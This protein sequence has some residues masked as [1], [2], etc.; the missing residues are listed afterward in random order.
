MNTL[1]R[2]RLASLAVAPAV[3]ALAACAQS[4]ST[5]ASNGGASGPAG[6]VRGKLTWLVRGNQNENDWQQNVALP[7][8]KELHPQVEI[9]LVVASPDVACDEKV[10]SLHAGGTPPDVHNGIVGTFIQLYAQDKLLELTPLVARD[11]VDLKP[12]GGSERDADMCRGGKQWALPILS[13]LTIITY[14]NITLFEQAGVALPPTSWEDKTWTWDRLIEAGRK[15]T[16]RWGEQDAVYG[17]LPDA[18]G[19]NFMHAMPYTWGADPWPK[20]FYAQGIAQQ[21]NWTAGPVVEATQAYQDLALKHRIAPRQG[22]A[23][24]AF[25]E[26]GASMWTTLSWSVFQTMRD[27]SLFKWSMAPLPRQA[28]NKA[29]GFVDC[30]LASNQSKAP[31]AAWQLVKYLTSKDGQQDYSRATLAPPARLDVLDTW[32]DALLKLPGATF[33]S[34]DALRDV[35]SGYQRNYVDNWAHYVVDAGRFQTLHRDANTALL[36]GQANAASVLTD[37]KTKV[38]T[39]L[40]E[41]YERF[42]GTR[43]VRDTLCQ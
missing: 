25:R 10:F 7:K 26:G 39:Q 13:A 19:G 43:L 28:A 29:I 12:F 40:K 15:T 3:G 14:Y 27:V 4:G 32:L 17:Y 21:S 42:K 22:A 35:I 1:T 36:S 30:V 24:R 5:P 37:M 23:R 11:K 20:E 34:R 9:E 38:D 33:K 31:D 2:R 6:A 8:M 18:I 41:T 16:Q